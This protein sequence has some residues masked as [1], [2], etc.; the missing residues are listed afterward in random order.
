MWRQ[1][2]WYCFPE[3]HANFQYH[4]LFD[5]TH[6]SGGLVST[7][8]Q[9]ANF[10]HYMKVDMSFHQSHLTCHG[11]CSVIFRKTVSESMYKQKLKI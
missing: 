7:A 9:T 5:N 1:G 6:Q 4:V 8:K 2:R 11:K 10:I 3:Y